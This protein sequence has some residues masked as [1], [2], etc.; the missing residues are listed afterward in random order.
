MLPTIFH[1]PSITLWA[2]VLHQNQFRKRFCQRTSLQEET[3]NVEVHCDVEPS[4][5]AT[6]QFLDIDYEK[7]V[8]E[9]DLVELE[10]CATTMVNS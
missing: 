8:G 6:T 1:V 2:P 9:A 7:S 10:D 3:E 5:A 4:Q